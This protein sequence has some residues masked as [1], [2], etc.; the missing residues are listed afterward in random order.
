M[1]CRSQLEWDSAADLPDDLP[2]AGCDDCDRDY[3]RD[4]AIALDGQCLCGGTL[5][6]DSE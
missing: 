6:E 5:I 1:T 4:I 2:D 3:A